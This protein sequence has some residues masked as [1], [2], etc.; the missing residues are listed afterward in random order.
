MG[1]CNFHGD[2]ESKRSRNGENSSDVFHTECILPIQRTA[3]RYEKNMTKGRDE[4]PIT[5]ISSYNLI[6]EWKP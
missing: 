6:L 4:Y 2:I 5:V 1:Y 3:T